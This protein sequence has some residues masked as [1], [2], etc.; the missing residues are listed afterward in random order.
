MV[1]VAVLS[2]WAMIGSLLV[3]GAS[4]SWLR[5]AATAALTATMVMLWAPPLYFNDTIDVVSYY[6]D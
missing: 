3:I 4:R 5:I 2:A 6:V 1:S